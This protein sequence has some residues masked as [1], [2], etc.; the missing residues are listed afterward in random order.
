MT[1]IKERKNNKKPFKRSK[2]LEKW[3]KVQN[4]SEK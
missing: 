1:N 4:E 2:S 3:K